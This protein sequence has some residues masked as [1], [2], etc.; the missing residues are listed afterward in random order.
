MNDEDKVRS[1]DICSEYYI[2]RK[3]TKKRKPVDIQFAR[4]GSMNRHC[5]K[6]GLW[7]F[8]DR[9]DTY[10]HSFLNDLPE[11]PEKNMQMH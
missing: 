5:L 9:I 2:I 11:S 7:A 6:A 10:A 3:A 4:T 8:K 1:E